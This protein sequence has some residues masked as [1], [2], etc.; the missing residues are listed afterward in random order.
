MSSFEA[1]K[2]IIMVLV[3]LSV[4]VFS[5]KIG[6]AIL[7]GELAI[8]MLLGLVGIDFS[9]SLFIEFL[10][11]IGFMFLLFSAGL[12]IRFLTTERFFKKKDFLFILLVILFSLL[13]V[14]IFKL[15]PFMLLILSSFSISPVAQVIREMKISN[16]SFGQSILRIAS[17]GEMGIFAFYIGFSSYMLF[18]FS[19]EFWI[20]IGG[21][22]FLSFTIT[23]ITYGL[24]YLIWW[25]PKPFSKISSLEEDPYETGV[26]LSILLMFLF[27]GISVIFNVEP[28]IGAFIAGVAFS[29]VFRE[30]EVIRRKISGL[31]YG[32]FVPVFLIFTGARMA[33]YGKFLKS[34]SWYFN[35]LFYSVSE[36]FGFSCGVRKKTFY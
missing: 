6:I 31:T 1:I 3:A 23:F 34:L 9:S 33:I 29:F 14:I 13:T 24:R 5:R 7:S 17:L 11:E 27:S 36:V 8:G 21:F 35:I 10:S 26:R 2:L 19:Y 30:K 25:V 4:P 15:N 20:R 16:S 22:L 12:E 32:F 18:G 28:G